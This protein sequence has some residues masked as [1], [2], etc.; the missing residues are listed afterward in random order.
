MTFDWVDRLDSLEGLKAPIRE[1]TSASE[2]APHDRGGLGGVVWMTGRGKGKANTGGAGGR[3]GGGATGGGGGG[4]GTMTAGMA[5]A[6]PRR[7]GVSSGVLDG[8][9]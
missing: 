1:Y 7:A 5:S 2:Q 6:T 4:S 3:E 9:S 8:W